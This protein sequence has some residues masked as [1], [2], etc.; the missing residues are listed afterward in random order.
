[1]KNS[2]GPAHIHSFWAGLFFLFMQFIFCYI[3]LN[4]IST[5]GTL[6]HFL[7][8]LDSSPVL[9]PHLIL[10]CGEGLRRGKTKHLSE[11]I[12]AN[13]KLTTHRLAGFIALF[14]NKSCDILSHRGAGRWQSR[15]FEL[16]LYCLV[17]FVQNPSLPPWSCLPALRFVLRPGSIPPHK[18]QRFNILWRLDPHFNILA[19]KDSQ[20]VFIVFYCII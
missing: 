17:Y 4:C 18:S 12:G 9:L 19:C 13:G 5:P 11:S 14:G 6:S 1:M 10:T 20:T 15:V 3:F 16:F 8:F 7:S 2:H